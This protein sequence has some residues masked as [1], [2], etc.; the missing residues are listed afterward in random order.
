[1]KKRKILRVVACLMAI[2]SLGSL[3]ACDLSEIA[4][5]LSGSTLSS[6][7]S[8]VSSSQSSSEE[9]S[10]EKPE[11]KP[12]P[13][14]EP[15]PDPIPQPDEPDP[16]KTL[17]K[18]ELDAIGHKVAYYSD[19]T[20]EDLGRETPL[21]FSSPA[22]ETQYGYQS[23]AKE[24]IG[25]GLCALYKDLYNASTAFHN[26]TRTLPVVWETDEYGEAYYYAELATLDYGKYD[27][28]DEQALAVWKVF[29]DENPIFYWMDISIDPWEGDLGVRVDEAYADYAVRSQANAAIKEMALEC[30]GYLS[31]LTTI[32]ERAL[33]IYDFLIEKIDY[34]Y[35]EDG[36][37]IVE[38]SWAYNIAGGAMKGYGVCECYAETYA[39]FCG[40]FGIQCL[41]VV[42]Y[43]GEAEDT[44]QE[45]WGGHAWNYLN[46]EGNWYAVD[47]TWADFNTFERYYFGMEPTDYAA[48]HELDLPTSEWGINYQCAMPDLAGELTPVLFGVE[49]G[50]KY[51]LPTIESAFEEMTD[52]GGRYEVTLY[53]ETAVS[54][55]SERTIDCYMDAIYTNVLPK[56]AHITFIGREGID[57]QGVYTAQVYAYDEIALRGNITLVSLDVYTLD[58]NENPVWDPWNKNGYTVTVK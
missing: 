53:P 2:F 23:F 37:T 57:D 19:G 49:G 24:Q 18:T 42:G 11:D 43:A 10:E 12:N 31:G 30:D 14:P 7:T 21:N 25:T 22:P 34:A 35:E 20:Y 54:E 28:T 58:R 4:A 33:T 44:T 41:N 51:M 52:E 26:S 8:E 50:E 16:E 47:I 36:F 38:E 40:L 9:N 46:L 55:K 5:M 27:L 56:A 39:Y 6:N 29:V 45:T 3:T 17:V 13:K 32:T 48:T 1:M 15:D